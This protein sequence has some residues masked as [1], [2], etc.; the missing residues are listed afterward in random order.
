MARRRHSRVESGGC[1]L[2]AALREADRHCSHR[3]LQRRVAPF[4]LSYLKAG[5][6]TLDNGCKV[7]MLHSFQA[8]VRWLRSCSPK[9]S[10]TR[11]AYPDTQDYADLRPRGVLLFLAWLESCAMPAG[12]KSLNNS[13]R[14]EIAGDCSRAS[15][16]FSSAGRSNRPNKQRTD[17]SGPSPNQ[18]W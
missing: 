3:L 12:C 6:Q 7:A 18:A 16:A 14:P 5:A 8:S 4:P 2:H 15:S 10:R 17:S 13:V 9:Y 1:K 11:D